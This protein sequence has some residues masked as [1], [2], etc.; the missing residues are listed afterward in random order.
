MAGRNGTGPLGMG[1]R[2]GRGLGRC[3][4]EKFDDRR[5][6]RLGYGLGCNRRLDGSEKS[7]LEDEKVILEER[8]EYIN[9]ALDTLE[10]EEE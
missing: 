9:K 6:R 10:N 5:P 2:T 8:L 1:P 7:F 4:T 3:G